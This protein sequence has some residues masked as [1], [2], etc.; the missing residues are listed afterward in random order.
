MDSSEN[1]ELKKGAGS[2]RVLAY[3]H[4]G[5]GVGHLRR[6]LNIC[7]Y[8]GESYERASFLVV[9]GSPYISLFGHGP[10]IDFLKLPALKK[11]DNETYHSKYLALSSSKV[12]RF[13]E[14]LLLETMRHF[15]PDVFIV[16]KAPVG[17]CGELIR[18]LRWLRQYRPGTKIIFGMRDIEDDAAATIHQWSKL[19]AFQVFEECY[20]E[21]WVYGMRDVYDVA[22]EYRLSPATQ[23][24]T[25]FMGYLTR[26]P[27]EHEV[28]ASDGVPHVLVT[29]GG[30]TDGALLLDTYL[31]EAA[32][33]MAATGAYSVVVAGPDLP[34]ADARRLRE[35]A[36][37][38]P[39][40]EWIDFE[41]CMICRI[42]QADVIVSMGGYNTLCEVALHRKPALV[43]PRTTPR[44][45]QAIRAK[46]WA[47]RG[48]VEVVSQTG[49]TPAMLAKQVTA[50]LENGP[51]VTAPELDLNGLD[52]VRER[53]DSFFCDTARHANTLYM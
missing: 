51:K 16:D 12:L 28:S 14:S 24:K 21:V 32:R 44:L 4:D 26:R 36:R 48:V 41:P 19:G 38:V 46:L 6:T 27:C 13:R 47:Q 49:L 42:R 29:V 52:R 9:T 31:A 20:D 17:V 18:T 1:G 23:A 3:C 10:N 7:E 50:M 35:V 40:T 34:D 43:I 53:F 22:R 15:D 33:Q 5:V 39:S 2:P 45:E 25:K 8:V 11:V 30:G 37:R